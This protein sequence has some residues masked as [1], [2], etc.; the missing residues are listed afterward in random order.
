[1]RFTMYQVI[2]YLNKLEN[3]DKVFKRVNVDKFKL[4]KGSY[5]DL[6]YELNNIVRPLPIFLYMQD[7]WELVEGD[8]I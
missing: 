5:G 7:E 1:M 8:E 3:K 2:S 4:F 6:M